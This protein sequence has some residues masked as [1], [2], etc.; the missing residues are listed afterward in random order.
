MLCVLCALFSE[1]D[2]TA[3]ES[4]EA[5]IAAPQQSVVPPAEQVF[6]I[7]YSELLEFLFIVFHDSRL[8]VLEKKDH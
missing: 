4:F 6:I 2:G 5:M 7:Y 8:G 3:I 1:A